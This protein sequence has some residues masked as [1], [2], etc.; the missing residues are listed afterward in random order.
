MPAP[1]MLRP[2]RRT[3]DAS[4]TT[5]D[6]KG[7]SRESRSRWRYADPVRAA[8]LTA[9]ELLLW[10]WYTSLHLVPKEQFRELFFDIGQTEQLRQARIDLFFAQCYFGLCHSVGGILVGAALG[11]L[12][13]QFDR[14]KGSVFRHR[15]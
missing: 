13:D 5:R 2:T 3:Q 11:P 6:E 14:R 8:A 15:N 10:G 7:R 4:H 9:G 1:D 12:C